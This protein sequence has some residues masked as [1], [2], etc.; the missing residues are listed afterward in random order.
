MREKPSA[1]DLR[2][3]FPLNLGRFI[4]LFC[5]GHL[6]IWL[7]QLHKASKTLRSKEEKRKRVMKKLKQAIAVALTAALLLQAGPMQAT[8]AED[9][10]DAQATES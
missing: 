3:A 5:F 8:A 6:I 2:G 7:L 1:A 10:D 9:H 4:V